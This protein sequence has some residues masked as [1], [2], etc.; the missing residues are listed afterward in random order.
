MRKV[1]A[2]EVTKDFAAILSAAQKESIVVCEDDENYV[3]IISMEDFEE[4]QRL[5][6]QKLKQIAH[7]MAKE[8]QEKGLNFEILQSILNND[9]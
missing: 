6:N 1:S 4:L 7:K 2:S 9:P 3:A 5:K 8:A